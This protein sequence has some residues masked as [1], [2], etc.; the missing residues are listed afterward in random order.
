MDLSTY[1]GG[2]KKG[3]RFESASSWRESAG[4]TESLSERTGKEGGWT[5]RAFQ[6][7]GNRRPISTRAKST[8]GFG[9]GPQPPPHRPPCSRSTAE[10]DVARDRAILHPSSFDV[11]SFCTRVQNSTLSRA[12]TLPLFCHTRPINRFS[13]PPSTP[14]SR[15]GAIEGCVYTQPAKNHRRWLRFTLAKNHRAL[16]WHDSDLELIKSCNCGKLWL[17]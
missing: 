14:W 3:E 1:G 8:S 17:R 13:L 4:R 16:G 15:S 5:A 10:T 7:L 12:P 2:T 9:G 11:A 6:F